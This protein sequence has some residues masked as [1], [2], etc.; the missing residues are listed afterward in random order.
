MFYFSEE[1]LA[2]AKREYLAKGLCPMRCL[3]EWR[4]G[5]N[6]VDVLC[7]WFGC[8]KRECADDALN[9]LPA[10]GPDPAVAEPDGPCDREM[11]F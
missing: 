10:P 3:D 11:P 6:T 5:R 9:L 4:W 1:D 8:R 2:R 7:G